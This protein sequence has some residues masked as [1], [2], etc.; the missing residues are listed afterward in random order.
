MCSLQSAFGVGTEAGGCLGM[1]RPAQVA[2]WRGAGLEDSFMFLS[3]SS[4][5]HV[6]PCSSGYVVFIEHF[7]SWLS[8][9]PCVGQ[10]EKQE[11][12]HP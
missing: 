2:G 3:S 6:S 8:A 9:E 10:Y 12:G 1:K 4:R 7:W 5:C 11:V